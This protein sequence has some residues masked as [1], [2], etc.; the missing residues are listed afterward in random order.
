MRRIKMPLGKHR[1]AEL[2]FLLAHVYRS[3][4]PELRGRMCNAMGK[5]EKGRNYLASFTAA[6]SIRSAN[7]CAAGLG[8]VPLRETR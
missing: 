6:A 7:S 4:A 8:R 5:P 2:P 3:K 1:L